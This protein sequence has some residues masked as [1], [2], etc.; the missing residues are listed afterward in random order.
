MKTPLSL[1]A[2][3]LLALTLQLSAPAQGVLTPGSAP[4]PSMKSLDQIEARTPIAST[5]FI[6]SAPGSYYL[7]TNLSVAYQEAIIIQT[8]GVTLD[9]NGFTLTSSDV[10]ASWPAILVASGLH[11]LAIRNGFIE[12]G[13]TNNGSGIYNGPGFQSGITYTPGGA[14]ANM[15]VTDVSVTGCRSDGI[16]IG[17]GDSTVVEACT[18]RT[19]GGG[20][21][22]ASVVKNSVALDC[23][24]GGITGTLVSD[25]RGET[26]GSSIGLYATTAEHCYGISYNG[27]GI[28]ALTV[29]NSYGNSTG[30]GGIFSF[31]A[32]N[33]IG[34]SDSY[35]GLYASEMATGC[36]GY[37]TSG[38]GLT[39][40]TAMACKGYS[41][42][43]TG[44]F[45]FYIANTCL[46]VSN[47][48]YGVYVYYLANTT[49]GITTTGTGISAGI[50]NTCF[51]YSNSQ[52]GIPEVVGAK[53]NMY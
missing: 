5:P 33:C 31:T 50:G 6:I 4:A 53:Y 24:G 28:Y 36:R 27:Y 9:L 49:M 8:N 17:A 40:P 39:A 11:N 7:T 45:A 41:T 26:T 25:S 34:V 38:T 12:S 23:G 22:Q 2:G 16:N 13:V 42:S 37:S 15:R 3:L 20:G 32:D 52:T 48:S 43:G 21:I 19:V 29:L 51:G 10:S 35:I 14:P 30:G 47:S 46:G 18:V 44:L 1:S